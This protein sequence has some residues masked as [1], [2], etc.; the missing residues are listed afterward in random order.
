MSLWETIVMITSSGI[1]NDTGP[2]DGFPRMLD[3]V[4]SW[5]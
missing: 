4:D 5:W 2:L 3:D 1:T